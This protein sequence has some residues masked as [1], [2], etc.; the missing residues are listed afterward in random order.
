MAISNERFPLDTYSETKFPSREN[1]FDPDL[2]EIMKKAEN[3]VE[4]LESRVVK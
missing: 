4:E 1:W 2:V 3:R